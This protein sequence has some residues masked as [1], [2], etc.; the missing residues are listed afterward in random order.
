M[1]KGYSR[2]CRSML[3]LNSVNWRQSLNILADRATL[4]V[5]LCDH[6]LVPIM[7]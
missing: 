2:S 4:E 5:L 7:S 6:I 1:H 3:G